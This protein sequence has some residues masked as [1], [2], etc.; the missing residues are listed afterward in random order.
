MRL[1][2][3]SDP[4]TIRR[5]EHVRPARGW[6]VERCG[7]MCTGV[8]R[9]CTRALGHTGPHVAHGRLGRVRAVWDADAAT[10]A[11][12]EARS[13]VVEAA[14]Q[15]GLP[16]RRSGGALR[17][18]VRWATDRVSSVEDL[19]MLILFLA[20]LGFAVDWFLRMLG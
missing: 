13:R 20:F 18:L 12:P 8:E 3:E 5:Y 11:R 17:A 2:I 14:R 6:G 7:V 15:G 9:A 19:A 10:R 16:S 1:T 4:Q